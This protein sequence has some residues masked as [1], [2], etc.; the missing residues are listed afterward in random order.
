MPRKAEG[1]AKKFRPMFERQESSNTSHGLYPS[2]LNLSFSG[3]HHT[4]IPPI[5][6]PFPAIKGH[7]ASRVEPSTQIQSVPEDQSVQNLE[8]MVE[9]RVSSNDTPDNQ[10]Q[11]SVSQ[12]FAMSLE[13]EVL[14]QRSFAPDATLI[15]PI[16][17]PIDWSRPAVSAASLTSASTIVTPL[18][19]L[20]SQYE[21]DRQNRV[22]TV[23]AETQLQTRLP[24]VNIQP[25]DPIPRYPNHQIHR[26]AGVKSS[27]EPRKRNFQHRYRSLQG[28]F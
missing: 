2:S 6:D 22:A 23:I 26:P 11:E 18:K 10:S 28:I 7:R 1:L 21:V 17:S 12:P 14:M 5:N 19:P 3:K 16:S 20:V 13:Q 24:A 8:T 15:E 25:L 4:I 27:T 9:N